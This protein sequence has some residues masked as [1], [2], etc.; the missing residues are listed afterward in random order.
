MRTFT[1]ADSLQHA[2][3][4]ILLEID[5]APGQELGVV[6]S[7][8]ES[9]MHPRRRSLFIQT[10][11]QGSIADRYVSATLHVSKQLPVDEYFVHLLSHY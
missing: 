5:K 7:M 8:T 2:T 11:V 4:P 10:V 1:A 6:L 3:G 9:G